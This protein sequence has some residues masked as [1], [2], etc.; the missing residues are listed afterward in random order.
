VTS[1]KAEYMKQFR[2]DNTDYADR[3]RNQ[4]AARSRALTRLKTKYSR[5]YELFYREELEKLRTRGKKV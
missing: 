4:K 5:D 3:D 2:A 1:D